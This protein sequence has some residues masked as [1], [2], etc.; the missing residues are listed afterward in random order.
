MKKLHQNLFYYYRGGNLQDKEIQRQLENNVT[1]AFI[2]VL[3][4]SS[5][6]V[7]KSLI[8]RIVPI[9]IPDDVDK[10]NYTLQES[11]IGS[12]R[13]KRIKNRFLLGVSPEGNAPEKIVREYTHSSIP[14]AWIWSKNFIVLFENKIQ[15]ELDET[16]LN[17][18]NKTI[19]GELIIK[20]WKNDIYKVFKNI[21]KET[22]SPKDKLLIREFYEFLEM[23]ELTNFTGFEKK[24]LVR[25]YSIDDRDEVEYVRNKFK[26]LSDIIADKLKEKGLNHKHR[27]KTDKWWDYF[28]REDS[29]D[30]YDLAHFSIYTSDILGLKLHLRSH[31]PDFTNFKRKLRNEPEVFKNILIKLKNLDDSYEIELTGRE[32]IGGYNTTPGFCF[33]IDSEYLNDEKFN[34]LKDLILDNVLPEKNK[35]LLS[36]RREFDINE[37]EELGENLIKKIL[38]TVDNWWDIYSY[39]VER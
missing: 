14:D 12:E 17:E 5:L 20:S 11:T 16:Q 18:H 25:I 19:D 13:I 28:V 34:L 2:N 8:E 38:D 24:D 27:A 1:K 9:N 23:V 36:I 3:E 4:K 33:T 35:I 29:H 32:H 21:S 26:K 31:N 15:C 7:Q 30:Y 6:G 10:I 39:I 22:L 37:A